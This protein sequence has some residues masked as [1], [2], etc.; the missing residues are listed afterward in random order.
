MEVYLVQNQS[1]KMELQSKFDIILPDS[2]KDF[3]VR[4][5]PKLIKNCQTKH[6]QK[7]SEALN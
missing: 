7:S 3:F 5:M 2:E 4:T 1:E 6:S